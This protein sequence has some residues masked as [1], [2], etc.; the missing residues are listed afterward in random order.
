MKSPYDKYKSLK[1]WGIIEKALNG[2]IKNKDISI[3]TNPDYVIGF[4][5]KNLKKIK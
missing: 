1:E 3:T 5:I 2:L 4:L